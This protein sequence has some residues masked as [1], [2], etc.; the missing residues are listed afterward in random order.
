M[1]TSNPDSEKFKHV[2]KDSP[3]LTILT[4]SA[5]SGELQLVFTHVSI[6]NKSHG[7]YITAFAL[8]GLLEAPT[9]ISIN[10]YTIFDS[11]KDNIWVPVTK[12]LLCAAVSNP[13]RSK[14]QRYC[15]ALNAVLLLPFLTESAILSSETTE[16]NL[17]K[18]FAKC[19]ATKVVE[20]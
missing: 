16:T 6:G 5:T 11:A 2:C 8:T 9:V 19:I 17:P 1:R 3:N 18:V 10:S 4:K 14:K 15:M 13:I 20:E 12:V 7:K